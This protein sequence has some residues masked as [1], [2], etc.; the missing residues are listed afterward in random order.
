VGADS[1]LR[2]E[3]PGEKRLQQRGEIRRFSYHSFP[4]FLQQL[5]CCRHQLRR[6]GEIPIGIGD[7]GMAEIG[8]H[9]GRTN[10]TCTR[11]PESCTS[12]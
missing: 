3:T 11:L 6:V 4:P 8:R 10:V 7:V 2:D 9:D 5:P 12:I 1:S